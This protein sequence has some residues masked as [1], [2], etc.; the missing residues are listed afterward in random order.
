MHEFI[1]QY[2]PSDLPSII[3]IRSFKIGMSDEHFDDS[4]IK[5]R[6]DIIIKIV[7]ED[8]VF[9]LIREGYYANKQGKENDN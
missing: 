2:D 5:N 3:D 4:W 8:G 6:G 1:Y 9:I 7:C